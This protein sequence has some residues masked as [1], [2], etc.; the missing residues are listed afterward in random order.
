MKNNFYYNIIINIF[1][2]F[3]ININFAYSEN[4][5]KIKVIGNDR[6]SKETIIMFSGVD[7]NNDIQIKDLNIAIKKL[8][9]TDY[10]K[11]IKINTNDETLEILVDENPII[12]SIKISGIENKE[13]SRK[14]NEITKKIEKYPFLINKI[15]EQKN[16]LINI[17]RSNGFYFAEIETKVT[18]NENNSVDIFYN[19]ETGERAKIQKIV[20]IGNKV[21]KDSKLRNVVLSEE[22]KFWKIITRN[23]YLDQSRIN[24]DTKLLIKFFK[25]KGYYNVNI[26]SSSAKVVDNNKFYLTFNIDAGDKYYFNDISLKFDDNYSEESFS[27]F[28]KI[29][30]DLKGKKYS[31][32]SLNKVLNEIDKKALQKEFVFINAKYSEKVVDKNKIN[33]EITLEELEK[34]YVEKINILGNFIT[35]EK[36]IRNS[37]IV[38][39]GDAF[40]KILFDKSINNIKSKNIFETVESEIKNSDSSNNT[41]IINITVQEKPTGEIFA[42]AGTGTSGSTL[43]AGIKEKNYLGKGIKLDSN[44]SIS[45]DTLK[46]K[47]K[48]TNPNYK[49]TDKSLN[50]TLESSSSD[51][52]TA[53]GYKTT[54]TGFNIGTGFEQYSDLFINIDLSNYYEK[55]ET[56]ST[57]SAIKKKQEGD[58]F[59]NLISYTVTLNKLNQN[60]QPS[61]GHLTKFSQVLPIYSDDKSIE[62]AFNASKYYSL[63]E[64]LILSAKLFI[65]SIN[66]FDDNVRASKR[67]YIPASR[68]RGFESGKI[69]PKDGNEYVGGNYGT[70]MSLNSTVPNFLNGYENIDLNIF[71]DAANL[72]HVDYDNTLD[73]N[74]IR[75]A[76]GLSVNW[77]TPIGPLSFSYSIPLSE[78]NTDKTESFRFRI[79]TSF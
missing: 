70:A 37:L 77:F 20:F 8:Y 55:L 68:L 31:V 33:I 79:G 4:F 60:F 73:S 19:V 59:E 75:S 30:K 10:F 61:D 27:N 47:F 17:L 49:N 50:T 78:K 5:K 25:N 65:K 64:D 23:K 48:V 58:Y 46:G 52:M 21:F 36:V 76:T 40:N 34:F 72:W 29:F 1:F 69:G 14:F 71:F 62:N 3:L 44:L 74:K 2:I 38:D 43:T 24:L 41:K 42:G 39:E 63:S 28:I 9:S 6:L 26:K 45:D 66:S 15:T 51:F 54:R 18:E 16:L 11:D 57:A 22:D 56:S 12:Q 67:I 13:I 32:K 53:S 35:E 7:I